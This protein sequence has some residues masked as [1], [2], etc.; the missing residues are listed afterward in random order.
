MILNEK[1]WQVLVALA[2]GTIMVPINTSIVN[3]AL[4]FI[5][6]GFNSNILNVEWVITS[7]LISLLGLVLFF[8]SLGDKIGHEKVYISGL[9]FFVL[10]SF[11]CSLSPSLMYLNIFRALQGISGAMM[12]SV[13]LGM[14]K[15]AFQPYEW[16]KSLGIYAMVIAT[17]LAIGPAI[18]GVLI[19]LFGWPSIFLANIP[20]GIISFCICLFVLDKNP[21]TAVNWDIPGIILQFLALFSTI[22]FLNQLNNTALDSSYKIFLVILVAVFLSLFIWRE[23]TAKS[24]LLDLSLFQNHKF[25]AFNLALFFNY[26]SLYMIIFA[27]PF[28]IQ[29]VLHYGPFLTGL[30]LTVSPLLMMIIAPFSGF[31]SDRI[32]SRPLAFFGSLISAFAFFLMTELTIFSSIYI[33]IFLMIILGIGTAV[34]QAP[35]NRAIMASIPNDTAGQASSILVT[36]RN[37]GM[38]FAVS[39]G[40]LLIST[41]INYNILNSPILFNLESYDFTRGLHL[42]AILGSV[43][44]LAMAILSVWGSK[45]LKDVKPLVKEIIDN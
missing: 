9:V 23:K 7:Y 33:V 16:G 28:Y 22:L 4:P 38:I 37:L 21:G 1:K 42:I 32:G 30:V 31:S 11:L 19:G 2:L 25:S 36:M 26:M 40:S 44:S 6:V 35:N 14:V 8:G 43:L 20:I 27:L 24:P 15:N 41:T 3:V 12:I 45:R 34:F 17:G 29:K 13:S 10:T 5:A 39:V 18:G